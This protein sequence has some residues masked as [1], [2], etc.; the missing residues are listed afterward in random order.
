ML[1]NESGKLTFSKVAADYDRFRPLYPPELISTYIREAPLSP[2]AR[3]L[4]VGCGTGQLTRALAPLG[5]ALHAVDIG[6]DLI[7]IAR[8]HCR[9]FPHVSFEQIAFEALPLPET[10]YDSLVCATSFHWLDPATRFERAAALLRAGGTLAIIKN[11]SKH[12][13][14]NNTLRKTL[15]D[16]YDRVIPPEIGRQ[17]VSLESKS[18]SLEDSFAASPHFGPVRAFAYPHTH[19]LAA[20]DYIRLMDTFSYQH[21]LPTGIKEQ[22]FREVESAIRDFGGSIDLPYEAV[23]LLAGKAPGSASQKK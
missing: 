17:Y 18:G 13:D 20:A 4:E 22:L 1:L 8:Q 6:A 10:G 19:R 2:T 3:I 11:V 14:Q 9:T 7:R 5:A 16:I 23:L 15:D 21:N 12:R